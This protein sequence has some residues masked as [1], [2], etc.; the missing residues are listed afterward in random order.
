METDPKILNFVFVLLAGFVCDPA[1]GNGPQKWGNVWK[2][3][4]AVALYE[5]F[6]AKPAGFKIIPRKDN[7][8]MANPYSRT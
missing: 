7:R 5:I 3:R 1:R 2:T 4:T 6:Y 8:A